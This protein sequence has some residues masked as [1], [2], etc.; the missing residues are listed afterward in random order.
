MTERFTP[1]TAVTPDLIVLNPNL[2]NAHGRPR[3]PFND[4]TPIHPS[5]RFVL[6][7]DPQD[8]AMRIIDLLT[9]VGKGQRGLI[10][11]P[12][13]TGKTVLLQQI[14]D[15]LLRNHPECRLFVLLI[16][17]RPEE[18]TDMRD[19]VHGPAAEIV[20]STFDR[21]PEQHRRV[22]ETTLA[23]A[24]RLVEAGVDVVILL[25]SLTR[26]ARACNCLAPAGGK[27]LTGGIVAGRWTGPSA[28]SAQPGN[29][30]KAAA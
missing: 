4:L 6:E 19:K 25:D 20:A 21:E 5:R 29:L 27:L 1:E 24:K 7:T 8:I 12:P 2:S 28:S 26:L 3:A 11:A 18:V 13:R 17:E 14:A 30:K 16:D 22:A 10:V 23:R 9:P 15:G